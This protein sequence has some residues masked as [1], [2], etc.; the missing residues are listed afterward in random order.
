M[1]A[2]KPVWIGVCRL[3]W[4]RL[5]DRLGELKAH[6]H[7]TSGIH[8][9]VVLLD[10][11]AIHVTLVLLI[12]RE[13]LCAMTGRLSGGLWRVGARRHGC[14]LPLRCQRGERPNLLSV[15]DDQLS[16]VYLRSTLGCGVNHYGVFV[17][18][19]VLDALDH[20]SRG[21]LCR[22]KLVNDVE[23]VVVGIVSAAQVRRGVESNIQTANAALPVRRDF[24][25]LTLRIMM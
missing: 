20:D 13:E 16:A 7:V 8:Q 5:V 9:M 10:D 22:D 4:S 19:S 12:F 23:R 6:D 11:S 2:S 17:A 1:A 25:V 21:L 3:F 24:D 14:L 15:L 18:L